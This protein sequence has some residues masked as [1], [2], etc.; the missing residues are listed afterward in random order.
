MLELIDV[1]RLRMLG[2]KMGLERIVL[3]NGVM[4]AYFISD[5]KHPFFES[6]R[7]GA[8]LQQLAARKSGISLLES[9]GKL[10]FKVPDVPSVQAAARVLAPFLV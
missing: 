8:I 10:Y 3:K 1:V 4:L 9:N 2:G 7:F 6:D 5:R